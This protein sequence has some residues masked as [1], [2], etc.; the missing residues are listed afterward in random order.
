MTAPRATV[1][2]SVATAFA[3]FLTWQVMAFLD[4]GVFEYPI[5]DVYIHLALA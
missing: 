5:D 2:L 4:A 3:V 1:L